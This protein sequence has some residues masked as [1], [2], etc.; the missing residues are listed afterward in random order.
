[1]EL[2]FFG[3]GPVAKKCLEL[4][5]KN[6]KIETIITKDST[7]EMMSSVDLSVPVLCANNKLELNKLLESTKFNSKIAVLIDFG[8]IVS[9]DVIS[10][11]PLGII[12]SHFSRLPE[13]RGADPIT[14]SI[15]SGQKSTGVTLMLIDEGMDTGKILTQKSIPINNNDSTELTD[16]LIKLSDSLLNKYLPLY[17]DGL[18][19]PRNQS[20]PERATYSSK[21]SKE[22]GKIDWNKTAEVIEREIRAYIEWPRS[23][24]K[25][26]ELD[27]IIKKAKVIDLIGAPG[28]CSIHN[29]NEL[30]VHCSKG[31]LLIEEIQPSGKKIMTAKDFLLGYQSKII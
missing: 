5:S 2:V 28:K 6:F 1:M 19:S 18:I 9:S 8:I 3:S 27:V 11:F 17:S 12:N 4:L 16:R 22:D 29:K 14:Y 31:S 15:L 10:T 24:T 30:V 23:Y 20:H 25:I 26:G 7:Q 21:L 13:W